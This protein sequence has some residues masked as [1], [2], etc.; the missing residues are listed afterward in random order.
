MDG[1]DLELQA[2]DGNRFAAY[3]ATKETPG[4]FPLGETLLEERTP[5]LVIDIT[6]P[7]ILRV[8]SVRGHPLSGSPG[9]TP[10]HRVRSR[11]T[12]SR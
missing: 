5:L 2:A 6:A 1:R 7:G 11:W 3:S 8:G 4:D 9:A 10:A 12:R